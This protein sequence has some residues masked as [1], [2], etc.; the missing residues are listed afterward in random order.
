MIIDEELDQKSSS[1]DGKLSYEILDLDYLLKLTEDGYYISGTNNSFLIFNSIDELL[2]LI[3]STE[4]SIRC[5]NLLQFSKINEIKLN[6]EQAM[7]YFYHCLDIKEKRDLVLSIPA[8]DNN[9]KVWNARNWEC[10]ISLNNPNGNIL[11]AFFLNNANE[12][13][14]Y[15]IATFYNICNNNN[16]KNNYKELRVYNNKG[17]KVKKIGIKNNTIFLRDVYYDIIFKKTYLILG[18]KNYIKSLDYDKEVVYNEYKDDKPVHYSIKIF[19]ES[20]ECVKLIEAFMDGYIKIWNFHTGKMLNN[21]KIGNDRLYEIGILD[22]KNILVGSDDRYIKIVN[23]KN[24]KVKNIFS[25]GYR[26]VSLEK[27]DH[28]YLGEYI[29]SLGENDKQIF[30]W[31]CMQ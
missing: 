25:R 6:N 7:K 3:Y 12:K 11:S 21:I 29:I 15:I 4:N 20:V 30:L 31:K 28:P 8:F 22:K 18:Y 2:I 19:R 13:E 24:S 17:K 27:I 5:Y 16:S 1:S 14:V 23:L 9:I 26:I 10:I